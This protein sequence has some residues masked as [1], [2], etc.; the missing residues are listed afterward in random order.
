MEFASDA[1][2]GQ[3]TIT[4]MD[5]VHPRKKLPYLTDLTSLFE[6]DDYSQPYMRGLKFKQTR[7]LARLDLVSRTTL[8]AGCSPNYSA[9]KRQQIHIA[10][11]WN[12][13]CT[14]G[15]AN[16]LPEA[17]CPQDVWATISIERPTMAACA[18]FPN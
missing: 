10:L 1:V 2:E 12:S 11:L 6:T 4:H 15:I 9:G 16:A 5:P 14:S 17:H 8:I 3:Y 18:D 13:L 7:S